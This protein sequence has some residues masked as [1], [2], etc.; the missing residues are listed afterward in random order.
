M[1]RFAASDVGGSRCY[2]AIVGECKEEPSHGA[3]TGHRAG[4]CAGDRS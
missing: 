4:V 3:Q 2:A 1:D